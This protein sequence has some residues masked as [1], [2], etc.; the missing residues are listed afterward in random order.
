MSA[1]RSCGVDVLWARSEKGRPMPLDRGV[2]HEGTRFNIG[3]DG[4]AHHVT[5]DDR[6]GHLS[7]FA[8]C[9]QSDSWRKRDR[10]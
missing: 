2:V 4:I 8:T 9:N 7:H 6:P 3:A 1:C 5:D 10:H